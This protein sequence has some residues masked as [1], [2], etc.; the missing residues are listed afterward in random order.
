M[1][2]IITEQHGGGWWQRLTL[3]RTYKHREMESRHD[4]DSE[5]LSLITIFALE[6]GVERYRARG[7]NTKSGDGWV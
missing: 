6:T 1:E 4:C 7:I 5:G 3:G 2:R